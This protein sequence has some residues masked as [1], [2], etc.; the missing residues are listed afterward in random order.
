MNYC[1]FSENTNA[2]RSVFENRAEFQILQSEI[3][4]R[5]VSLSNDG[6]EFGGDWI[7]SWVDTEDFQDYDSEGVRNFSQAYS[8]FDVLVLHGRDVSQLGGVVRECR[9][10]LSAK[11][12]VVVTDCANSDVRAA[13]YRAG[14]DAVFDADVGPA[15][16]AA[17][18]RAIFR[19][20]V[21]EVR[22][23]QGGDGGVASIS[24]S[25]EWRLT[26]SERLIVDALLIS[27]GAVSEYS[28]LLKF[29]GH[30]LSEN[31]LRNLH[32]IISSIRRKFGNSVCIK[33]V[34]RRGY[35]F[36]FY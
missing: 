34:Q 12:I 20:V 36:N 28:Y 27:G 29:L 21:G 19:R 11:P 17:H 13:I 30:N 24:R 3:F 32:V 7:R 22:S 15:V 33:N 2:S 6:E 18:V 4:V 35:I 16:A 14:A 23:V 26:R 8:P 5:A 25:V 9:A 10:T 1:Q 31:S